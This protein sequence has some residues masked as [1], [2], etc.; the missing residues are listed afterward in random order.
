PPFRGANMMDTLDQVRTQEPVPPSRLQ[1]KTPRDLETITLKCLQ[2]EP[3]K[4]YASALA[5]AED[6]RR[7]QDGEPIRAR[8]VGLWERGI[9]WARRRPA[10][11][12]LVGALFLAACALVA[13]S[14]LYAF[15]AAQEADLASQRADLYK[16]ELQKFQEQ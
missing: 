15:Y 9:K 6:L 4:R 10:A 13:C 3:A 11:A 16:Q 1:P 8:P 14:V 7:Y 12:A 2:K 5:L